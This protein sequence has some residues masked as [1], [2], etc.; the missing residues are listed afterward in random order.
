MAV[1]GPKVPPAPP[2]QIFVTV[3][4]SQHQTTIAALTA[5]WTIGA[6]LLAGLN[7]PK[8]RLRGQGLHALVKALR[9]ATECIILAQSVRQALPVLP[10][11]PATPPAVPDAPTA[12]PEVTQ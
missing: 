9:D 2:P 8:K 10:A 4:Q 11:A 1:S 12:T 5:Q 7:T 6:E 3:E